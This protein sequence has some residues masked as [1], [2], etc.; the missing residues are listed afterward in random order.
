MNISDLTQY[1]QNSSDYE[2]ANANYRLAIT[3][4][5][6]GQRLIAAASL[7]QAQQTLETILN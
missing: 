6:M 2:K 3:A 1:S 7:T 4:N 5:I